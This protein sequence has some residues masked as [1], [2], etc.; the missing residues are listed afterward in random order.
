MSRRWLKHK[1]VLDR[2][3]HLS[4]LASPAVSD[5][6]TVAAVLIDLVEELEGPPIH[7]LVELEVGRPDVMWILS[8]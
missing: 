1:Q 4:R 7:R 8:S 2:L 5:D 6:Q 3:D